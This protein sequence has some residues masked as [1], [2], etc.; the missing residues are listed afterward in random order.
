MLRNMQRND[1][2]IKIWKTSEKVE[3]CYVRFKRNLKKV[4]KIWKSFKRSDEF[5]R[6][7]ENIGKKL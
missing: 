5:H 2:S 4:R 7:L 6:I 1:E 3:V